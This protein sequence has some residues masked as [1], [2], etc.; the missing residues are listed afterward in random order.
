MN[1]HEVAEL[2][3]RHEVQ[4]NGLTKETHAMALQIEALNGILSTIN[5]TLKNVAWVI[6]LAAIAAPTLVMIIRG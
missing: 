1:L 5:T 6:S 3:S 2:A 4:I